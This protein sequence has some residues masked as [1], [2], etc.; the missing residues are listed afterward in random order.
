MLPT[1]NYSEAKLINIAAII[2]CLDSDRFRFD[3]IYYPLTVSCYLFSAPAA[4]EVSKAPETDDINP[5]IKYEYD[6]SDQ[7]TPCPNDNS[8]L[9]PIYIAVPIAGVCILLALIIFAM[10]LLRRRSD[11]YTHYGSYQYHEQLARLANK[12]NETKVAPPSSCETNRCTDSER[13]SQGSE[14]KLFLNA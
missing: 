3:A 6:E 14:T 9:Y 13:S 8:K 10:Y 1:N 2:Y 11:M 7:R 5:Y 4:P 12:Q